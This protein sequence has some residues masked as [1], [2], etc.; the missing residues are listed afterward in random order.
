MRMRRT[1]LLAVTLVLGV[2]L[3]SPSGAQTKDNKTAPPAQALSPQQFVM[4]ASA[5]GLA[6]VNLSR[7]AQERATSPEVK[8]FAQHM[9]KDH[10]KANTQLLQLA[11]TERI[12]P[13]QRMDEKHQMLFERLSQL[14]G[15]DFDRAYMTAMLQDH[16]Q[17]VSLF[18][19]AEKSLT[20]KNLQA[21]AAKTLPTLKEH[22]QE[23]RKVAAAV[24]VKT[25]EPGKG[26]EKGTEKGK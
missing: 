25:G 18:T 19:S 5:S 21:F 14:K 3:T 12:P 23:A 15:Q 16:E 1:L 10:S 24:G 17:A 22:L 4:K 9:V 8:Q 6:E 7:L 2:A 26:T 20:D 11:N 13:A